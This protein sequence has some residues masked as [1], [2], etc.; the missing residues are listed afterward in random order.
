M[1]S[2]TWDEISRLCALEQNRQIVARFLQRL[3]A[4]YELKEDVESLVCIS[5]HVRSL[6]YKVSW[7]FYISEHVFFNI[8]LYS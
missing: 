6:S 2:E 1:P 4:M 8:S 7:E 3:H 5:I